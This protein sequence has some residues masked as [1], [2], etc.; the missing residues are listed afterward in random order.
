[1]LPILLLV[2]P[3]TVVGGGYACW[4]I[5]QQTAL[6]LLLPSASYSN[7]SANDNQIQQPAAMATTKTIGNYIVGIGTFAS[8][9][10]LQSMFFSDDGGSSNRSSAHTMDLSKQVNNNKSTSTASKSSN[11]FIP[12]HKR[13]LQDQFQPPKSMGEAFKRMGR[14][15][16][17]RSGSVG[18]AFFFAGVVQTTWMVKTKL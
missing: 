3:P 13:K 6:S 12:P 11:K 15:I 2:V 16:L 4:Y 17:I 14:P 5:G 10:G 7:G 1:M 18:V 9:Y 8:V